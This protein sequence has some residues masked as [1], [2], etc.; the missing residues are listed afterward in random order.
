MET[1]LWTVLFLVGL[2]S[3]LSFIGLNAGLRDPAPK[4]PSSV[5]PGSPSG[6]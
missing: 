2:A 4:V 6:A 1:I 3:V 5:S